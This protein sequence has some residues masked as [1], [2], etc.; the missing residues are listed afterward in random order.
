MQ[1]L[2]IERN[3]EIWINSCIGAFKLVKLICLLGSAVKLKGA[4]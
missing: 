3:E 4:H 2:E 1:L